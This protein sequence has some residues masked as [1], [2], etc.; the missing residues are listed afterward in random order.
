M[1]I[2]AWAFSRWMSLIYFAAFWSLGLQ[3][4]GL[5]GS[6]GI[7]PAGDFLHYVDRAGGANRFW[8][9]PT[10]C[11]FNHS[12]AF[13]LFL[14]WGGAVLSVLLMLG[15]MPAVT[16]FLLWFFY[17]S[18]TVAGQ[19]FLSFQW[20]NLLLEAGFLWIFL[21]PNPLGLHLKPYASPSVVI[22]WLLRWLLFRLMFQ[23]GTIK[24]LSADP[25]WANLTALTYHY[26]TQPLP[27][28]IS[29]Y[30]NQLPF[31]F[32]KFS[33]ALLL[34]IEI[35]IPFLIFCGRRARLMAFFG[36]MGLQTVII[37]T[38]NYCF[39]N[40]LT[41]GLCLVLLDDKHFR[42]LGLT[43]G[44]VAESGII[45]K[46]AAGLVGGI[47][48]IV[49]L[50][51]MADFL[52]FRSLPKPLEVLVTAVSPL[53]SINNY[54]LFAVMT[55]SRHEIVLE[56]SNDGEVWV[57]YEFRYKPGNIYQAPRWVM[58]H[59]PRLD[60]Q[61]W[62]AALGPFTQSEWVSALIVRLLQGEPSVIHLLA[63]NPFKE[64]PPKYIEATLWDYHFTDF[65]TRGAN[66][67]WWRREYAGM[68]CPI[69][70]L[71]P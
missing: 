6:H 40:L 69:V 64:H 56:G 47:V 23:S 63:H 31:W 18:L 38:G 12:D 53:R 51:L 15:V 8:I 17:L 19:D 52:G 29:W 46:T 21:L 34:V 43:T 10:L 2:T 16:A 68:Y 25:N 28:T 57:P 24:L 45:H 22:I 71:R 44:K 4:M 55:T 36:I 5:I 67:P 7:L 3:V 48:L 61:M 35:F 42:V 66:G 20:D 41:M 14:C 62:F 11:W 59:Q 65:K 30:A 54:G 39:F 13:L 1:V 50:G 37:L 33:C 49:S 27:N 60:W 26:W 32:Q 58:P 9:A 70:S